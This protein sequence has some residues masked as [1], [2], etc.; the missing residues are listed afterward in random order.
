MIKYLFLNINTVPPLNSITF[1]QHKIENN[2][3]MIQLTDV[4]CELFSILVRP[5]IYAYNKRLI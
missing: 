4:F 5:A 3:R 2:N 1:G